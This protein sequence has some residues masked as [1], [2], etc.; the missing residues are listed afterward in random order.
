M[1]QKFSGVLGMVNGPSPCLDVEFSEE[2]PVVL[3][4]CDGG[5]AEV[6]LVGGRNFCKCGLRL[7][8]CGKMPR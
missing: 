5:H 7:R 4:R 2:T 1:E 8:P 6:R 3:H